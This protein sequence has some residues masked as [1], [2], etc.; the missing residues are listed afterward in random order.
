MSLDLNFH[1]TQ[2]LVGT[3]HD[4]IAIALIAQ[5]HHNERVYLCKYFL[6]Y[7]LGLLG[8]DTEPDAKLAAFHRALA[9]DLGA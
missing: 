3:P 6:V 9:K 1:L 7:V 4:D 5:A 2:I 8:H